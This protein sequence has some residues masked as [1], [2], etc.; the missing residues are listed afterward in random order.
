M[1]PGV[2]G[3]LHM[4]IFKNLP[5]NIVEDP[6]YRSQ[7]KHYSMVDHKTHVSTKTIVVV[8]F[9]VVVLIKHMIGTALHAAN[10][11]L[12]CMTVGRVVGCTTLHCLPH[13]WMPP[14]NSITAKRHKSIYQGV[15]SFLLL[16]WRMTKLVMTQERQEITRHWLQHSMHAHRLNTLR[17]IKSSCIK[18]LIC[19]NASTNK[20]M[21]CNMNL[22]HTCCHSHLFN[23]DVE[24][25][26]NLDGNWMKIVIETIKETF[27][28]IKIVF[29]ILLCCTTSLLWLLLLTVRHTGRPCCNGKLLYSYL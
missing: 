12:S 13:T 3:W 8:I 11:V 7:S 23:L 21:A 6:D 4:I 20:N 1:I 16:Q 15:Y 24:D 17:A 27:V 19:D 26:I 2:H 18:A 5:V 28:R 25:W 10:V 29:V 9:E 14:Q 22:P